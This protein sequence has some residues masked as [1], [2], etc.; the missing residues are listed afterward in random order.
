MQHSGRAAVD[1]YDLSTRSPVTL[2]VHVD[3]GQFFVMDRDSEADDAAYGPDAI[4]DGIGPWR[5]G[6]AVF[7][8][9]AWTTGTT[10]VVSLAPQEPEVD[11]DAFDHV[12]IAGFTCPS[13]VL[14]V[15]APEETGAHERRLRLQ[16]GTYGLMVCSDQFGSRNNVGDNGTDR[17]M[18]TLWPARDETPRRALKRGLPG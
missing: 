12:V 9:S 4:A 13:G 16:P 14:R 2:T 15:F 7:C 6:V 5:D 1:D 10:V 3:H 18:L 8:E 17:Y 11:L